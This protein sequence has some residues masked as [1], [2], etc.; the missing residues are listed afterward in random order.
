M[1]YDFLGSDPDPDN[2][3]GSDQKGRIR[4]DLD[5]DFCYPFTPSLMNPTSTLL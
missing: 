1:F 5:T 4:P 2:V 3:T